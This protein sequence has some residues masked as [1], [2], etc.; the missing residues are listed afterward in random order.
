MNMY[1]FYKV[2]VSFHDTVLYILNFCLQNVRRYNY[3]TTNIVPIRQ[4]TVIAPFLNFNENSHLYR[5]Y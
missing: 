4:T 2:F 3:F 1:I 5:R